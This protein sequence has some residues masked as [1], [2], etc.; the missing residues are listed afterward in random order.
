[1]P[2]LISRKK[3]K[4]EEKNRE[5]NDVVL[6]GEA[7]PLRGEWKLGRII[8]TYPGKDGRVRAAKVKT[9]QGVYTRPVTKLCLL[10]ESS[11]KDRGSKG[12]EHDGEE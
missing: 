4:T 2:S 11:G 8:E 3:W 12:M 6:I 9:S 7:G 5:V 1:L 10:E